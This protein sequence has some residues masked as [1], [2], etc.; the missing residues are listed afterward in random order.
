VAAFYCD[1]ANR[2]AVEKLLRRQYKPTCG[3]R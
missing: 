1:A 3:D 2:M